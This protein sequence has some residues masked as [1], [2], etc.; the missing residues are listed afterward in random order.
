MIISVVYPR[1]CKKR[2]ILLDSFV[3]LCNNNEGLEVVSYKEDKTVRFK[4]FG[5][6]FMLKGET[7]AFAN[8]VRFDTYMIVGEDAVKINELTRFALGKEE[9]NLKLD[10]FRDE[11]IEEMIKYTS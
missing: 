1:L 7:K 8:L 3:K 10:N 4:V 9:T 2:K 5:H 11:Y 6:E